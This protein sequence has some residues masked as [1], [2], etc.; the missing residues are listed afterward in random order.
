MSQI[1]IPIQ[2]QS[3]FAKLPPSLQQHINRSRKIGAELAAIHSVDPHGV[4][5]GIIAH[6]LAR[7]IKP[8]KLLELTMELE[9]TPNRVESY[10]P[11]LL[12]GP[13]AAAWLKSDGY[14]N[15][16]VLEAVRY[17]STGKTGMCMTGK[18]VFL[19]DKLDPCKVSKNPAL[20]V[21]RELSQKSIDQAILG[22]LSIQANELV[23]QGKMIHPDLIEFRNELIQ[24]MTD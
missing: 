22:Y 17:H 9:L 10:E 4:D 6:D 23:G 11:I 8:D 15:T 1:S 18:I 19:S 13:V 2:I 24:N 12:H 21:I 20:S 16:Q 3:R 14:T 5:I 7:H